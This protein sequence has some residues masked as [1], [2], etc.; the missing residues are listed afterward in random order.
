[1]VHVH[2]AGS[3]RLH[4]VVQRGED[5][6]KPG[7]LLPDKLQII[8]VSP[9]PVS[10]RRGGPDSAW[11]STMMPRTL[12]SCRRIDAVLADHAMRW[13]WSLPVLPCWV[14]FCPGGLP[15]SEVLRELFSFPR[16]VDD[17]GNGAARTLVLEVLVMSER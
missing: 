15:H 16:L 6:Q 17:V 12:G 8:L 9:Q 5:L 1:M 13:M 11:Q 2:V 14:V 10:A 4:D 3:I 7:V